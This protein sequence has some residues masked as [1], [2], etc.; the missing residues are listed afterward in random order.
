MKISVQKFVLFGATG[1]LAQRMVWP[2]LYH[3]VREK[4]VP[5]SLTFVGS[6]RHPT[7]DA[8]FRTFVEGAL[9]KFV[10]AEYLEKPA[11]D[12]L[13]G[14]V[15]YVPFEAGDGTVKGTEGLQKAL[16]GN[17]R[18]LYF[19][20][21]SPRLYGPTCQSLQAAG[22][23]CHHC[24]VILEKP[25]GQDYASSVAINEA[26]GKAFT[27]DQVF[28]IDH[29]LGKEAV[30][31]LL[32][33]R[34]ANALFEPL[35]NSTA[36]DHVQITVAETVGVEG[37][38]GYYDDAGALRDMVQNHMLQLVALVAMEPPHLLEPSEV[39]N[40]K[41][42]VLRS[43]RPIT[44]ATAAANT[45]RGQYAAGNS[46]GVAVPGYNE[47]PGAKGNS[48]TETFVALRAEI[49]NWRWAGVPF[50]LRTG[51]RMQSRRTDIAIQF[52]SVPHNIFA[53]DQANLPANKLVIH[54]QP[55]ESVT[56]EIL[57]KQPGLEGVRLREVPLELSLPKAESNGRTRIAYERLLLDA[58]KGKSTLFVRRDE[59]EAAWSW[60]DGIQSS[61]RST[62]QL[63][64]P[65]PAGTWGPTAAIA[66]TERHGHSWYE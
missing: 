46:G 1:D 65:Y 26:V 4:L 3:L 37:R 59:V 43:L 44:A 45:V 7:S 20:A 38:W 32:A 33:L 23:A 27:E 61:W 21:T 55:Q 25:I 8:D 22:L 17:D 50:Y 53:A 39:R 15:T 6:A 30:Q 9:R 35:W 10:P 24:R 16:A 52:K 19:M 60:I 51:K 12:D 62:R 58:F 41:T 2:S 28:R 36:I 42:K 13:L 49:D 54:L 11:L 31:N 66:L 57:S 64:K 48:D 14:R 34:F 47:E 5:A 40:E 29:Y 56:L 63:V 18:I